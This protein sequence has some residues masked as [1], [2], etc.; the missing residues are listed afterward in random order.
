MFFICTCVVCVRTRSRFYAVTIIASVLHTCREL[1]TTIRTSGQSLR[2]FRLNKCML[3]RR[4]RPR[5][6]L[7]R[8][9]SGLRGCLGQIDSW[10]MGPIGSPE[11]LVS[12]QLTLRKGKN[13][14]TAERGGAERS[15]QQLVI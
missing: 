15:G 11:T 6:K 5:L 14:H 13:T 9:S 8:S 4:L 12:S 10:K 1:N 2:T 7:I 3:D